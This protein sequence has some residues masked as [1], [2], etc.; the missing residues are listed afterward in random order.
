MTKYAVAH[1][2]LVTGDLSLLII[3]DAANEIDACAKALVDIDPSYDYAEL[4]E[5]V[6]MDELYTHIS[7]DESITVLP[8]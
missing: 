2:D 3:S 4:A 1:Y 6:D 8:V 5:C 7:D